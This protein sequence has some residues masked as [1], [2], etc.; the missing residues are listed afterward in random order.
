MELTASATGSLSGMKLI[1]IGRAVL[2]DVNIV[3]VDLK[4][5]A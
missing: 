4:T 5:A 2:Q 3:L 1:S